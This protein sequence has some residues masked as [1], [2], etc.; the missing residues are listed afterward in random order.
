MCTR[1]GGCE[2]GPECL[3]DDE[4]FPLAGEDEPCPSEPDG[5]VCPSCQRRQHARC[6]D[7]ECSCCLGNE[8]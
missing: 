1:P 3:D 4:G 5:F 6:I 8:D 7:P 2:G